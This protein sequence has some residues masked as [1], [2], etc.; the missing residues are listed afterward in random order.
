MTT[1]SKKSLKITFG[2]DNDDFLTV[3]MEVIEKRRKLGNP[4]WHDMFL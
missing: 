4:I 2:K 3:E 1:Q